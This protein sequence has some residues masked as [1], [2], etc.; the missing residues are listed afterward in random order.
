[1]NAGVLCMNLINVESQEA[2]NVAILLQRGCEVSDGGERKH[3]KN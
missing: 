2:F 3:C 1:M